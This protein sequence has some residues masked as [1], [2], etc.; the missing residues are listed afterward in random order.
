VIECPGALEPGASA[1]MR[2]SASAQ[3]ET[4]NSIGERR[5]GARWGATRSAA[6]PTGSHPPP[7]TLH[8]ASVAGRTADRPRNVFGLAVQIA[9]T[10]KEALSRPTRRSCITRSRRCRARTICAALEGSR[11]HLP[12]RVR[13]RRRLDMGDCPAW[14]TG[15]WCSTEPS[16]WRATSFWRLPGQHRVAGGTGFRGDRCARPAGRG[17]PLA[18][19]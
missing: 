3:E 12:G 8:G 11:T 18:R 13:A 15:R 5:R 19:T 14:L 16:I 9:A 17:L 10:L 2:S 4:P 1:P 6:A 7:G